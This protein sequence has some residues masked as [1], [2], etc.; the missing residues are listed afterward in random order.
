MQSMIMTTVEAEKAAR[1]PNHKKFI[2]ELNF[3]NN[4]T[5]SHILKKLFVD[6]VP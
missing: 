2:V 3:Q 5:I 1:Y 4:L 6:L